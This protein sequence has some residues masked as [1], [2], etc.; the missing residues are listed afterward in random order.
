MKNNRWPIATAL[1]SLLLLAGC[2]DWGGQRQHKPAPPAQVDMVLIPA[3]EFVMGSN[4]TDEA[5]IQKEYG[6][7]EPLFLDEHPQRKTELPAFL[8]DRYEVT[9]G[10]YKAFVQQTKRAE[11]PLWIKNGYNVRDEKLQSFSLDTLR[12]GATNFFKLDMDTRNMTREA[13]LAELA[14]I[15]RKR[16]KLPV[17]VV[18]WADADAYCRWLGRRLPSEAEW[19]KAARG[20]QGLEYP[21]GNEWDPKKPNTGNAADNEDEAAELGGAHP[22]DKSFY[23]VYDMAGNVSEWVADWYKPYPGS[24]FVSKNYGEKQKVTRGGGAGVGHYSLSFF[25]RGALRGHF[26][27]ETLSSDLGFR[28]AAD[29]R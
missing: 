6:F 16:D 13:I 7:V 4:K 11:P 17:T 1:C 24:S 27:P 29:A 25:Y 18:S 28:C 10:Q 19:E 14:K 3:G 22:G 9:N 12:W 2:G 23:G 26:D 5:K 15:Q 21:W 8:I 20:P